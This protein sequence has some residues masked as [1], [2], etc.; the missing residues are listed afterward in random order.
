[1][2]EEDKG[3]SDQGDAPVFMTNQD[4]ILERFTRTCSQQRGFIDFMTNQDDFFF[5]EKS[6]G[7]CSD[8]GRGQDILT[9]QD[10]ILWKFIGAGRGLRF[11]FKEF[12]G[13]QLVLVRT[14]GGEV[15]DF[16]I[17]RYDILKNFLILV[18]IRD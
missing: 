6:I 3:K 14:K 10:K 8:Q 7:H 9:N 18:L 5:F 1:M 17:N 16:M 13:N 15:P 12:F 4:D 11:H 2:E